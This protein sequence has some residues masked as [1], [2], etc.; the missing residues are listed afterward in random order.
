MQFTKTRH[1]AL[2]IVAAA[3]LTFTGC[4]LIGGNSSDDPPPENGGAAAVD[5]AKMM[6][7]TAE[8]P[9]QVTLHAG[10]EVGQ[11]A[12]WADGAGA[13][14]MWWGV[15]GEKDGSMVVE[16][17]IKA[18]EAWI[19][20]AYVCDGEGKVS[21][22]YLAN[23]SPD[24]EPQAGH[25]IKVGTKPEATGETSDA[26]QPETG[27]ESVELAGKTWDCK[28]YLSDVAGKASKSWTCE[29]GWFTKSIKSDYDGKTVSQLD[30]VG[31]DA[32]L[33]LTFPTE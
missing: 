1:I 2:A 17:R 24:G 12:Q 4:G 19:T 20:Y 26:P 28:W 6:A 9:W 31:T 23:Y 14:N 8:A 15:T 3:A 25:K 16:M 22:A 32:A 18:G 30:S 5:M 7:D 11:W 21:E 29:D 27:D 10:A 33:G 13:A